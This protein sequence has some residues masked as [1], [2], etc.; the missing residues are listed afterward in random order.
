[1]KLRQTA[2]LAVP[3]VTTSLLLA[4]CSSS[5]S[6]SSSGSGSTATSG[7]SSSSAQSSSGSGGLKSGLKVFVIP[8]NLGNNYF[9]TADS[10]KSG[11][12]ICMTLCMN[13][14]STP[15]HGEPVD[16]CCCCAGGDGWPGCWRIRSR[17]FWMNCVSSG[18]LNSFTIRAAARGSIAWRY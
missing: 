12:A 16:A 8:K 15:I 1:M 7:A 5:G 17:T 11:G 6:S 3:L 9:T 14:R 2:V 4:A 10:A 13:L 18:D